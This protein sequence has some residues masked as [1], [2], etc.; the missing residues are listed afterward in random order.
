M[1]KTRRLRRNGT[2]LIYFLD[3]YILDLNLCVTRVLGLPP[4]NFGFLLEPC[5]PSPR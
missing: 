3:L 2:S 5:E 4:F 1:V